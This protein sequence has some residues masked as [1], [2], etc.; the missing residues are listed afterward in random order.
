MSGAVCAMTLFGSSFGKADPI[1]GTQSGAVTRYDV[2]VLSVE[3]CRSSSCDNPF[4]MGSGNKVF[5]IASVG[6]G[7]EVGQFIDLAGIPLHETWTHVRV[8]LDT[9]FTIQAD[10]GTCQTSAGAAGTRGAFLAAAASA[11]TSAAR[12]IELPNQATIRAAG[13]GLAAYDY[14]TNGI[15]QTDGANT[16]QMTIAM[17]SPYICTGEM[18]RIEVQFDTSQAFG[19]VAGCG[20]MFPQ[21]PTITITALDP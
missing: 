20:V 9:T 10:D 7:A 13:G 1:A 18:P 19:Y 21:P 15:V 3:L 11:G 6:A 14:T 16:F 8:T 2:N 4:V 12:Q 17:S 5:D